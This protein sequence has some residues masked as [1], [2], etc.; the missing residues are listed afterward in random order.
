MEHSFCH[1]YPLLMEYLWFKHC[2]CNEVSTVL[3]NQ[4][5]IVGVGQWRAKLIIDLPT[6]DVRYQLEII[7]AINIQIIQKEKNL[8]DR[9]MK[10]RKIHSIKYLFFFIVM[11]DT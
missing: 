9:W 5:T 10:R 11:L 2:E 6:A 7:Y 3:R 8:V 1:S 4:G